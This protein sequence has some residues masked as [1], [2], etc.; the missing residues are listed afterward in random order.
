ME[1]LYDCLSSLYDTLL[2]SRGTVS[3]IIPTVE[4]SAR[5]KEDTS[6]LRARAITCLVDL[7]PT[8][9]HDPTNIFLCCRVGLPAAS[10]GIVATGVATY[11]QPAVCWQTAGHHEDGRHRGGQLPLSSQ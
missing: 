10:G 2:A 6:I 11:L 9:G 1:F 4:A 5:C 8:Y 3:V 7:G